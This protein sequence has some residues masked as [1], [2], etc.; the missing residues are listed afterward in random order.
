MRNKKEEQLQ[1]QCVQ[2]FNITHSTKGELFAVPNGGSRNVIEAAHMK[3]GGVKAG[4]SDLIL[5]ANGC[6]VFL[7]LK[8]PTTY[9]IGKSGKKVIDKKGGV[10]SEQQKHFQQKVEK[11]G[12]NYYLI[13]DFDEFTKIIKLYC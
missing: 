1:I 5:V 6:T 2:W 12:H 13:D 3:R 4:V 8:A 11:L 7:E 10:Q 9:K